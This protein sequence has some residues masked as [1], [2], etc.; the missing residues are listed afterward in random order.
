MVTDAVTESTAKD[1]KEEG[2]FLPGGWRGEKGPER[3]LRGHLET[4]SACQVGKGEGELREQSLDGTAC[5]ENHR[6]FLWPE[7]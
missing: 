6:W 5:S 1:T 3:L 7:D 2:P 4:R